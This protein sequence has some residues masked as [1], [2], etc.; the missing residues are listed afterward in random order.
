[1]R[2]S[3]TCEVVNYNGVE[4]LVLRRYPPD[5]NSHPM[6]VE[7]GIYRVTLEQIATPIRIEKEGE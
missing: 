1:M 7:P 3:A 4:G 2:F 6:G 5:D